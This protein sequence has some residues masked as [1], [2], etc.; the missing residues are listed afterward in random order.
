MGVKVQ[1]LKR[2]TMFPM[3]A[4][5]LSEIYNSYGKIE[6]IPAPERAML[7]KSIFQ[8]P[9]DEIWHQTTEYLQQR[10]SS[11]LETAE[12]NPKYKMGL[13]FKWY[14]GQT[15]HWAIT[16]KPERKLDYQVWCGPAMGAF[17]E[18][19]KGTFLENVS[20]RKVVTVALNLLHG[21]AATMR[22]NALKCQCAEFKSDI[23]FGPIE[24]DHLTN[25]LKG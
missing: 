6:D 15:P 4:S 7:E 20:N 25:Y 19:T 9:L 23:S 14:L 17:N 18:W 13:I 1:V 8:A 5:K 12:K 16:G 24:D 11:K 2:G 21:A 10:D 22:L 3:R